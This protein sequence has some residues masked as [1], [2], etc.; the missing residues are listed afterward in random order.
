M[1]CN[2]FKYLAVMCSCAV[3]SL[4]SAQELN[5]QVEINSDQVQGTNKSVFET[6]QQAINDY[7]NTNVFTNAQFAV[8]E[9]ID[10]RLY[11]TI[12]EINDETYSGDLQ[13][14]ATRPVYNTSY[15]TTLLNFKDSKI[16][17]TYQENE[18]LIFSHNNM[19]SQL[20]AILN[21][22]AYLILAIDFDSFSQNGG[23]PYFDELKQIVQMAQSSGE[24]G[25]KAFED[26][27]NR[28]AVLSSF[29]DNATSSI[30]TLYYQYHRKGLDEMLLSPDKGRAVITSALSALRK[31]YDVAPMSVA[32]SLFKDAK[33]DELVNLYS[34]ASTDERTSVYELLEPIY[35]AEQTRL[36]Q[37]KKGSTK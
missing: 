29:T 30:R 15:T 13:V 16:D 28:S 37:I 32:L 5:C 27:K 35:P 25:W 14:Q 2:V 36:D 19:E 21:F 8:N 12:K 23:E 6:L 7:M 26:T 11:F 18:P 3:P 22:Y 4:I 34:K 33:F 17:F 31:V 24:N 1:N 20:T 10:C 9:K